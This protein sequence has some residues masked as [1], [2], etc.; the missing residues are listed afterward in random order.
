MI[1]RFVVD[2]Q[3]RRSK[4]HEAALVEGGD[5]P[6]QVCAE[7][8][9][10]V[11]VAHVARHDCQQSTWLPAEKV[12]VAEVGVLADYDTVLLVSCGDHFGIVLRLPFGR[13]E[14]WTAS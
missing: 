12:T 11:Y 6:F 8:P 4:L 9:E 2:N 3:T 14:P 13:S 10:Q 5:N 7:Q 1:E